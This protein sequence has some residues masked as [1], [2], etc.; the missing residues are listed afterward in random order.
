MTHPHAPQDQDYAPHRANFDTNRSLLKLVLLG[1]ITLGIYSAWVIARSGEDLNSIAG[2]WD[3]KRSMN[4]WL[5]AI[6]V[7][8]LTLGIGHL[9][10]WHKTSARIGNELQRRGLNPTVTAA[11]FWLWSILGS[12]IIIGPFIFLY[13]W[14]TAMNHLCRHYN[15]YG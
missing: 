7:G 2:R 1:F 9:V 12:L 15:T 6:V 11:D 4:F 14:L 3:N 13:K 5:L 8:P 10:W